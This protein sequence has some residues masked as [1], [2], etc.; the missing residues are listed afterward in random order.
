MTSETKNDDDEPPLFLQNCSAISRQAAASPS[1]SRTRRGWNLSWFGGGI[2]NDDNS[3]SKRTASVTHA[4]HQRTVAVESHQKEIQ[5]TTAT[6]VDKSTPPTKA[7][8]TPSSSVR[9]KQ[10]GKNSNSTKGTNQEKIEKKPAPI[11]SSSYGTNLDKSLL[12]KGS[13][14]SSSSDTQTTDTQMTTSVKYAQHPS[15]PKSLSPRYSGMNGRTIGEEKGETENSKHCDDNGIANGGFSPDELS[16]QRRREEIRHKTA[17]YE[18]YIRSHLAKHG[19]SLSSLNK[20]DLVALGLFDKQRRLER[21][22][23]LWGPRDNEEENHLAEEELEQLLFLAE[24]CNQVQKDEAELEM[25]L[26]QMENNNEVDMDRLYHLE[27]LSR[28]RVGEILNQEELD[29]LQIFEEKKKDKEELGLL[30]RKQKDAIEDIDEKRLVELILLE[31]KRNNDKDMTKAELRSAEIIEMRHED[32]RLNKQDYIKILRL[33]EQGRPVDEDRF[34]LL[35]MLDRQRRGL[36]ISESEEEILAQYFTLRE[37]EYL[38]RLEVKM[39]A[40]NEDETFP[41]EEQVP[42]PLL[43]TCESEDPGGAEKEDE[44]ENEDESSADREQQIPDKLDNQNQSVI[45]NEGADTGI[46][47]KEICEQISEIE[48]PEPGTIHEQPRET[49]STGN[50]L[51]DKEADDTLKKNSEV[52]DN[53]ETKSASSF[54]DANMSP[55]EKVALEELQSQLENEGLPSAISFIPVSEDDELGMSVVSFSDETYIK[56]ILIQKE[57]RESDRQEECL[58]DAYALY[59]R[60]LKKQKLPE[61]EELLLKIYA[62]ILK[63]RK[64][65]MHEADIRFNELVERVEQLNELRKQEPESKMIGEI[66]VNGGQNRSETPT[67]E[68]A[69]PPELNGFSENEIKIRDQA[70]VEEKFNLEDQPIPLE[71]SERDNRTPNVPQQS[72]LQGCDNEQS[73]RSTSNDAEDDIV[74]R[75]ETSKAADDESPFSKQTTDAQTNPIE[76]DLANIEM[77]GDL[78]A[79]EGDEVSDASNNFQDEMDGDLVEGDEVYDSSD[80]SQHENKSGQIMILPLDSQ[81]NNEGMEDDEKNVLELKVSTDENF[82]EK[83]DDVSVLNAI[84][85]ENNASVEFSSGE[86]ETT[87]ADSE[88]STENSDVEKIVDEYLMGNEVETDKSREN[89]TPSNLSVDS[90]RSETRGRGEMVKEETASSEI[91]IPMGDSSRKVTD[92]DL[93]LRLNAASVSGDAS[94]EEN[95][96]VEDVKLANADHTMAEQDSK[97]SE[98]LTV[99]QEYPGYIEDERQT[100][101]HE[102]Y[103]ERFVLLKDEGRR[104]SKFKAADM[105]VSDI[106]G[107]EIETNLLYELDLITRLRKGMRLTEKQDYELDLLQT[108]RRGGT[109]SKEEVEDFDLLGSE[110]EKLTLHPAFLRDLDFRIS[111]NKLVNDD[112]L[113]EIELFLKDLRGEKMSDDEQFELH[114]FQQRLD[115]EA[116]SGGDEEKLDFLK[117]E[118]SSRLPIDQRLD[119]TKSFAISKGSS[120]NSTDH[121]YVRNTEPSFSGRSFSGHSF[122]GRSSGTFSGRSSGTSNSTSGYDST[123]RIERS[124]DEEDS[125]Y[126]RDLLGRQ[127]A[128]KRLDKKEFEWLQILMKKSRN[129]ELDYDELDDLEIMRNQRNETEVDFVNTKKLLEKE[130]R[131]QNKNKIKEQRRKEKEARKE[132]RR[133]EKQEREKMKKMRRRAK[134]VDKVGSDESIDAINSQDIKTEIQIIGGPS[135]QN[136]RPDVD[137]KE[138]PKI[139][140]FGAVF[141]NAKKQRQ[142][143]QLEEAKRLQEELIKEQMKALALENEAE[144]LEREKVMQ[145]Q[146]VQETI[147]KKRTASVIGSSFASSVGSSSWD[148]S[149]VEKSSDES[150]DSSWTSWDT[151]STGDD[152]GE[153]KEKNKIQQNDNESRENDGRLELSQSN[154]KKVESHQISE[155]DRDGFDSS[156]VLSTSNRKPSLTS[157]ENESHQIQSSYSDTFQ[158][159]QVSDHSADAGKAES[160]EE[161]PPKSDAKVATRRNTLGSHLKKKRK[162][163]TKHGDDVSLGTLKLSK[164]KKDGGNSQ[165]NTGKASKLKERPWNL[166]DSIKSNVNGDHP[167]TPKKSEDDNP[168]EKSAIEDSSFDFNHSLVSKISE[169]DDEDEAEDG[170]QSLSYVPSVTEEEKEVDTDTKDN[171][172]ETQQSMNN[173]LANSLTSIG[174]E[175]YDLGLQEYDNIESRLG[176]KVKDKQAEFDLTWEMVVADENVI[177]QINQRLKERQRVLEVKREKKKEKKERKTLK[178]VPRLFLFE[179]ERIFKK[180]GSKRKSKKEINKKLNRTLTREFRKAMKDVFESDSDSD[181]SY[182]MEMNEVRRTASHD[183]GIESKFSVRSFSQRGR[184]FDD[185][186]SD[187]LIYSDNETEFAEESSHNSDDESLKFDGEYLTRLKERSLPTNVKK[188]LSG[189]NLNSGRNLKSSRHLKSTRNMN[190][191]DSNEYSFASDS[192]GRKRRRRPKRKKTGEIVDPNIDPAEVYA[193]ELEKQKEKKTFTIAGIRKEMEGIWRNE[194]FSAENNTNFGNFDDTNRSP[195]IGGNINLN[196]IKKKKKKRISLGK[197]VESLERQRPKIATTKSIRSLGTT[198]SDQGLLTGNRRKL[199][200]RSPS[201]RGRTSAIEEDGH[202]NG[203]GVRSSDSFTV[204]DFENAKLGTTGGDGKLKIFGAIKKTF[205]PKKPAEFESVDGGGLL[206]G[207]HLDEFDTSESKGGITTDN[208]SYLNTVQQHLTRRDPLPLP[209]MESEDE[210]KHQRPNKMFEKVKIKGVMKKLKGL[211]MSS[212]HRKFGGGIMIDD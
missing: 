208:E 150:D 7:S 115:G 71:K 129:E 148:T 166:S 99:Q 94:S 9:A 140:V 80:K 36:E 185:D 157:T 14:R 133:L 209:I 40:K 207:A 188:M 86:N 132:Q 62:K 161:R 109:L 153:Y 58:E 2:N 88:S 12:P 151:T 13:S 130:L 143:Q 176:G 160:R 77:N 15:S 180:K 87:E 152:S 90:I 147:E 194:N 110:R 107:E 177:I 171:A 182:Q 55:S 57:S 74:S 136:P 186:G 43:P 92:G 144:E 155:V 170:S 4:R 56:D 32:E 172:I 47:V 201:G 69:I 42:K 135:L 106:D 183:I 38:E 187:P 100:N 53:N 117:N 200:S 44:A 82:P 41:D 212:H 11:I 206:N 174:E 131:R 113:Y 78:G 59:K 118:R 137:K 104:S 75:A 158:G 116:L 61:S 96:I 164:A 17:W 68:E 105:P 211:G 20:E 114:L 165:N 60:T 193:Q 181:G 84:D 122:S 97:T 95:S 64:K 70:E 199:R 83:I 120:Q 93:L 125:V 159:E 65:E 21:R 50:S 98:V 121:G 205:K 111:H 85:G 24:Q 112:V 30:R 54:D 154:T 196:E 45:D 91:I 8:S 119:V 168:N 46:F 128:G 10:K 173:S 102:Q 169:R 18:E 184:D 190:L 35:D 52:E 28:Q 22:I 167:N 163:R 79:V 63:Q 198:H 197:G 108:L 48:S 25:L 124:L 210:S 204:N 142:E 51:I 192:E 39:N 141:K 126:R 27:L 26:E 175:G 202:E 73:S 179:G 31:R 138:E 16:R 6:G 66:T 3:M 29:T 1:K 101:D 189:R 123:E 34:D 191:D 139:G 89:L 72:T 149:S 195:L 19:G 5:T 33:K 127:M 145:E 37:E 23:R 67:S 203:E 178:E 103:E 49:E 156:R 81:R 134:S 146:L 76:H 162:K